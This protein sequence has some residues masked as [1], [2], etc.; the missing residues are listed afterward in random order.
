MYRM[1]S[2]SRTLQI[3]VLGALFTIGNTLIAL[4]SNAQESRSVDEGVLEE[5]VVTARRQSET[6]MEVPVT[7][8]VVS[9]SALAD[10]SITNLTDL[11]TLVAG[12]N[13]DK[14]PQSNQGTLTIRGIGSSGS[15]A[16]TGQSVATVVDGLATSRG[17][18][19]YAGLLDVGQIEVMKGPQALFFGKDAPGGIVSIR[20]NGPT[21]T[22]EGY[23]KA[24]YESEAEEQF[25]EAAISG[26][27]SDQM[28]ARLAVRA[29]D[30]DGW[31][32]NTALREANP[33]GGIPGFPAT[34]T[35]AADDSNSS[36]QVTARL[37]IDYKPTDNFTAT[38]RYLVDSHEDNGQN[39]EM[40]IY[41]C[42][43]G[44]TVPIAFG[45][46]DTSND[47]DANHR[48]T[49]G[50]LM[51]HVAAGEPDWDTAPYG[52]YDSYVA[53]L[54]LD[55]SYGDFDFTSV[56]GVADY[57][58]KSVGCNVNPYCFFA[59]SNNFTFNQV[60]Q[61]IRVVSNFDSDIN[62]M[63]GVYFDEQ[64]FSANNPVALFPLPADPV[65]GSFVSFEMD[66]ESESQSYSVFA[67]VRWDIT[68]TLR[69]DAGVRYSEDEVEGEARN[70]S[71]H[72]FFP[73]PLLPLG[74][75]VASKREFDDTSPQVTLTWEPSQDSL[76]FLSWRNGYKSGNPTDFGIIPATVTPDDVVYEPEEIDGWEAG[77][78]A[79]LLDARLR[80]TAAV[81][82]YDY[83]DLQISNFKAAT[84]EAQTLN[85]GGM[86]TEGFEVGID[87]RPTEA[88]SLGL[89]ISYADA[90]YTDFDVIGCYSGQTADQGCLPNGTQNLKGEE[91]FRAPEWTGNLHFKYEVPAFRDYVFGVT[92]G[93]RYSD[94]YFAQANNN[95]NARQDAYVVYDAGF[96]LENESWR[97]ALL[98]RNLGDE[99]YIIAGYDASGGFLPGTVNGVLS[100]PRQVW[101]KVDYSF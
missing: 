23:I 101:F 63:A 86:R 70:T 11:S 61:E 26:P 51:P 91:K 24:G 93:M 94:S 67:E 77:Y 2:S 72:S 39:S 90:E 69:L 100:R 30:V 38:F 97:F 31:M 40:E 62:F 44:T 6:L 79:L 13:L 18:F 1:N 32:T 37:T 87:Y 49:V 75:V 15:D 5:L 27:L 85:A 78:K 10:N 34:L 88:L 46:P 99:K 74:D 52:E 58:R 73:L 12:I 47:C 81:F 76:L 33:F 21:D 55:W 68:E 25:V 16:S 45:I 71:L 8:N 89:G 50:G 20:S 17:A 60:S 43:P 92:A 54:T 98:G 65:T 28:R 53:S 19:I 95:P 56:T 84:N 96:H 64:E 7:V 3:V 42:P 9:G 80:L 48:S 66:M 83:T 57:E 4:D 29:S 82:T 14:V 41:H 22:L 59:L 35:G 36:D